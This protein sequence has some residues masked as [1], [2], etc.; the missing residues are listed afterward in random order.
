MHEQ[1]AGYLLLL[2]LVAVPLRLALQHWLTERTSCDQAA[3]F[4]GSPLTPARLA[5]DSMLW[6]VLPRGRHDLG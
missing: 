5:F 3:F 2:S 1:T 6:H 4:V